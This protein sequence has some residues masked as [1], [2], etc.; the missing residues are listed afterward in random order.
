MKKPLP[1]VL[2]LS[3][4]LFLLLKLSIQ[5]SPTKDLT[6]KIT[7]DGFTPKEALVK[8]G[9]TVTFEN[10]DSKNRWPASNDHPQHTLYNEFDPLE[11]VK[12]R[13]SWTFKFEKPGTWKYH[14]HLHPHQKGTIIV[15][16]SFFQKIKNLLLELK[17][18]FFKT[19]AQIS[20]QE[21]PPASFLT[22]PQKE[23]LTYLETLTLNKGVRYSWDFVANNTP[24]THPNAHDLA[25]FL[26]GLIFQEKGVEGLNICAPIY[27]YG[28][29]HGFAEVA[30][31]ENLKH[32][33]TMEK[34][35]NILEGKGPIASCI[36]GIGHGV[37]TYFDNTDLKKALNSCDLLKNN[38]SY[39]YDGV[40]MEMA[41]NGPK[42]GTTN[43][44]YPCE[45]VE[46]QYLQ[47]CIR[48]Q[49][50]VMTKHHSL[51][52]LQ[53]IKTC[54]I[55]KIPNLKTYCIEALGFLIGQESQGDPEIVKR[56][57]KLTQNNTDFATCITH[58]A[59]EL[60]FQN[61]QGWQDTHKTLC[62]MLKAEAKQNCLTY[63]NQLAIDYGRN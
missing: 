5:A 22:L 39:C 61:Y 51:S 41:L 10:K 30:L 29:H 58:A 6:V 23:Q 53:I 11:P 42:R 46:K 18:K 55:S 28:C 56:E 62:N 21:I 54:Q 2:M 15:E 48:Q 9:Q 36:H 60:V 20:F 50:L 12:P 17:S 4:S 33:E 59:G 47:P 14:D 40:F 49:P 52:R 27:A 24:T 1:L 19:K 38:Q 57:C 44:L 16:A 13:E 25:H 35:C 26:G 8:Y 43:P 63:T 45:T 32:I 37:A 3:I 7:E 34:S 31:R